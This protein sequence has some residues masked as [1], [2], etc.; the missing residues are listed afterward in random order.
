LLARAYR[1]ASSSERLLRATL[2]SVREGVAT[3]D[4]SEHLLAWNEKFARLF[5]L[6]RKTLRKGEPLPLDE[7]KTAELGKLIWAIDNLRAEAQLTGRSAML[8]CKG[9]G[10]RSLEIFNNPTS[11]ESH[12]TTFLDITERRNT[13]EALR[14][15]QKLEA[16]GQMTGRVA[17]DFNNLTDVVMPGPI[18]GRIL[19]E[20]AR[21]S[22]LDSKS[23]SG[24]DIPRMRSFIMAILTLGS[25]C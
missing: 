12:V 3:F 9:P 10:D 21:R 13:E 2:D 24:P 16:L 5:G 22:F 6:S 18:S 20:R 17:H 25:S 19:A 23:C 4:E 11:G 1:Q 15:A 14:Q 7:T 8:E